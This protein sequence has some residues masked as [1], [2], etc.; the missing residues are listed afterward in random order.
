MQKR[1]RKKKQSA[2]SSGQ[3]RFRW[4]KFE[5]LVAEIQQELSPD[6]LVTAN[7]KILGRSGQIRQIDVSVRKSIGEFELL[8]I[9]DCKDYKKR[10]DIKGVEE[11]IG[12]V[13]DVGANKGAMVAASGYSDGAKKRAEQAGIDLLRPVHG[14][15]HPWKTLVFVPAV[16]E[17]T[18]IQAFS[19]KLSMTKP[20]HCSIPMA[21][22]WRTLEIFDMGGRLLGTAQ[23][24]IFAKWA[25]QELP[26]KTAKLRDYEFVQNPI[27]VRDAMIPG[28]FSEIEITADLLLKE[29]YYLGQISLQEARGMA[30]EITKKVFLNNIKM[31]TPAF[32]HIQKTW[33]RADSPEELAID[34]MF[35]TRAI[36]I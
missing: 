3:E 19:L 36:N 12:M 8:I 17:A 2:P 6:G 33:R 21:P 20:Q 7:D 34:P 1:S 29:E 18:Y 30:N 26:P 28:W 25:E 5:D 27:K 24:L 23:E 14:G 22:D 10:I 16:C 13:A 15:D 9:V 4:Q 32:E 35:L 11:F 31:E